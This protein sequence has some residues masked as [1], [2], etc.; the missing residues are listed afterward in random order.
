MIGALYVNWMA[1]RIDR[2]ETEEG[3]DLADLLHDLAVL[4]LQAFGD[5]KHGV[6][7]L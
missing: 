6:E 1:E 7:Q 2:I 3:F 4:E 5:T